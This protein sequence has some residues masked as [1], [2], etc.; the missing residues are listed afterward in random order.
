MLE[1]LEMHE[2]QD[3]Q[4]LLDEMNETRDGV[5]VLVKAVKHLAR[6]LDEHLTEEP[7]T[8]GRSHHKKKA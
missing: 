6:R 4:L 1:H 7:V 8:P 5:N 3:K 2:I